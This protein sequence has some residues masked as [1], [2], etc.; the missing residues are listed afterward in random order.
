MQS[1]AL[2]SEFKNIAMNTQNSMKVNNVEPDIR[3][4][5]F[6]LVLLCARVPSAFL[7]LP[8]SH[9]TLICMFCRIEHI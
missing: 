8:L 7:C 4:V 5:G 9:F 1:Y 3:I 6:A 2:L